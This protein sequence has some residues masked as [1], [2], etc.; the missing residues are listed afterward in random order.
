MGI[1][2]CEM[3][4]PNNLS[5]CAERLERVADKVEEMEERF[6]VMRAAL[7]NIISPYSVEEIQEMRTRYGGLSAGELCL[8]DVIQCYDALVVA[9]SPKHT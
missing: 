5:N 4:L 2:R 1:G 7:L 9:E 8:R 6:E 3:T